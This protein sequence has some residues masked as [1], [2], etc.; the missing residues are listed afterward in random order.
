MEQVAEQSGH[1]ERVSPQRP[2]VLYFGVGNVRRVSSGLDRVTRMHWSE[3]AASHAFDLQGFVVDPD[4]LMPLRELLDGGVTRDTLP[5]VAADGSRP[6][7]LL[8]LRSFLDPRALIKGLSLRSARLPAL[9]REAARRRRPD[10]VVID[11]I[12]SLQNLPLEWLLFPPGQMVFISHD[13]TPSLMRDLYSDTHSASSRIAYLSDMAKAWLL[14]RLMAMRADRMVFLSDHDQAR[15]GDCDGKTLA[16]LPIEEKS[17][18]AGRAGSAGRF[19]GLP[20]VV[21]IG[22]PG[23]LPNRYAIEWIRGVLAPPLASVAP[24]ARILLIG[25]GT[26]EIAGDSPNVVGLGFVSDEDLAAL[27]DGSL[28]LLSPIEHGSGLK[29]K[30]LDAVTAGIPVIATAK[31]LQGF[32]AFDLPFVI[33]VTRPDEAAELIGRM[34]RGEIDLNRVRQDLRRRV[35]AY[36]RARQGRLATLVTTLAGESSTG[37]LRSHA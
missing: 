10:V 37:A 11:H 25:K 27:L 15:Y 2:T 18:A 22:S 3:L 30:V 23:F 4:S 28:A 8:K 17:S 24:D 7:W 12:Y 33:D 26:V 16:L 29:I 13:H 20:Y 34:A 1:G 19:A 32:S 9:A 21:F 6:P 36:R 5:P 14:E 35:E 31:S